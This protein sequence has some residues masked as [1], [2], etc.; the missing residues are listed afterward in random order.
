MPPFITQLVDMYRL[1]LGYD[2]SF[3]TPTSMAELW[4]G[5]AEQD[6]DARL[7]R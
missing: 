2:E 7:A 4:G 5:V 1:S 6:C 3:R